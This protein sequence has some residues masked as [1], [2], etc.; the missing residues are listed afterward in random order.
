MKKNKKLYTKLNKFFQYRLRGEYFNL[1]QKIQK[2]KFSKRVKID[3]NNI[4]KKKLLPIINLKLAKLSN[5][6]KDI[7][8]RKIIYD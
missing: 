3:Y 8:L 2:N 4:L 1:Y 5:S 6:K 7:L